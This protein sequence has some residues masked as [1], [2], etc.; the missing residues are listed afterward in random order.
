MRRGSHRN[1]QLGNIWDVVSNLALALTDARDQLI[2]LI[3]FP[4]I[5]SDR[6]VNRFTIANGFPHQNGKENIN[7]SNKGLEDVHVG[8][9]LA[10]TRGGGPSAK[11]FSVPGSNQVRSIH[12][13]HARG[14][15]AFGAH[16][17]FKP[18]PP[19]NCRPI[20]KGTGMGSSMGSR[21]K[22]GSGKKGVQIGLFLDPKSNC[23][24]IDTKKGMG[25]PVNIN[26]LPNEP[27]PDQNTCKEDPAC[28]PSSSDK[29]RHCIGTQYAAL[30]K[31]EAFRI[32]DLRLA[33][34]QKAANS[35]PKWT[36][37]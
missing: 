5:G 12:R 17:E 31:E 26:F 35:R 29:K 36:R 33:E 20:N 28:R 7:H 14:H 19:C 13:Q 10:R 8:N 16:S 34:D 22:Q 23:L 6:N 11:K 27:N 1:E 21:R 15:V 3:N 25:N 18:Q 4:S 9:A 30:L 2:D 24:Q 32:R 37:C